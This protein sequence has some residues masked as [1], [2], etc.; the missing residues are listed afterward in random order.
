MAL[1]CQSWVSK[2]DLSPKDTCGHLQTSHFTPLLEWA[3]KLC[4]LK[5]N[6][7]I[8]YPIPKK[9]FPLLDFLTSIN[10]APEETLKEGI[11]QVRQRPH[12][13]GPI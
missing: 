1:L 5:T 7:P 8:L 3:I 2:N 9:Y 4:I 10:G 11:S 12:E 13:Q 6:V